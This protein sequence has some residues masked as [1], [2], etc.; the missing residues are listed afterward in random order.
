MVDPIV[1]QLTQGITPE[2]VALT[3]AVGSAC[4]LFPIVGTTTFLCFVIGIALR[5]NQPIIQLVNGMCVPIHIPAVLGLIRAGEWMFRE[6]KTNL[7]IRYLNHTFWGDPGLFLHRYSTI[8]LH[9]VVAWAAVLPIW[10]PLVYFIFLPVLRELQNIRLA[11]VATADRSP[12][13]NPA[14]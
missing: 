3:L 10:I 6:P 9:A 1:H 4:A 8:A 12:P 2:K 5:L 14:P 7:N 11:A 13:A